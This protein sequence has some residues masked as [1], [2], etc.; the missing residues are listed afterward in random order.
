MDCSPDRSNRYVGEDFHQPW[1]ILPRTQQHFLGPRAK[2]TV[3]FG[4]CCRNCPSLV[5]VSLPPLV[6]LIKRWCSS[7]HVYTPPLVEA[8]GIEARVQRR[9]V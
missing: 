5:G 1:A 4:G 6:E 8:A 2:L 3:Y 7:H 9:A